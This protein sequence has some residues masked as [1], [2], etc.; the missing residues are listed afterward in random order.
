MGWGEPLVCRPAGVEG[1]NPEV[2]KT[3]DRF[4]QFLRVVNDAPRDENGRAVVPAAAIRYANGEDVSPLACTGLTA[5]W[6]PIH[7]DCTCPETYSSI[8][9]DLDDGACPLHQPHGP[10]PEPGGE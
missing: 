2:R 4:A 5:R 1:L 8:D 3:L 9:R 6:C 10:H 7:G